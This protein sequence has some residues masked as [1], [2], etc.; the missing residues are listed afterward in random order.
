MARIY[1]L[2]NCA[3]GI[4]LFCWYDEDGLVGSDAS[5]CSEV[6]SGL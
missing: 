1:D 3:V 2:G 4:I 6:N 5:A